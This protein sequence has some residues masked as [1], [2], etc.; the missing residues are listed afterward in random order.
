MLL[1]HML[2]SIAFV[3]ALSLLEKSEPVSKVYSSEKDA[4]TAAVNRYNPVSIEQDREFIGAIYQIGEGFKFS[5]VP[6]NQGSD[7]VQIRVSLADLEDIVAFW[8][9]HGNSDRENRYFSDTDTQLVAT[10]SKPLYLG[11]YTGYLKVFEPE[12]NTLSMFAAHRLG[13]PS[14]RGYSV[15]ELVRDGDSRP[16]RINTRTTPKYC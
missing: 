1:V 16:V 2:G 11:D 4:V 5:V 9:T 8:H 7:Q 12:G 3:A 13:L 15:G 10:F 14:V 6:G